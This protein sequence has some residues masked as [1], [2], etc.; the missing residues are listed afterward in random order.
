MLPADDPRVVATMA[1]L[2]ERLWIRSA[3]G[4]IARY[5][6]DSY[7]QQSADIASIP[8]N[9]WFV[10]TLWVAEHHVATARTLADLERP[11]ALLEWCATKAL[12]SGVL[13]EQVS[14]LTGDPLSVSPLT[15]SHAGFV[16]AIQRYARR[17]V[18]LKQHLRE[19]V[20]R[21]GEV[22]G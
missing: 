3:I 22:M 16:A 20:K 10:A 2:E 9:P 15:W 6:N 21:A 7:F 12:P 18:A 8:G 11:R 13:A 1:A 4:G 19:Q 14:P 5:E 17:S